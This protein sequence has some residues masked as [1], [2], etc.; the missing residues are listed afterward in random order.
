MPRRFLRAVFWAAVSSA[1]VVVSWFRASCFFRALVVRS[2][3]M[4]FWRRLEMMKRVDFPLLR[5]VVTLAV[6]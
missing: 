1:S 3:G 2:G 4:P 5:K 6:V